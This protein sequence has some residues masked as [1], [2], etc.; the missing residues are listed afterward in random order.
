MIKN[1][2]IFGQ[3]KQGH[4]WVE[5]VN[6]RQKDV[7]YSNKPPR[8]NNRKNTKGRHTQ[9]ITCQKGTSF[10]P[11]FHTKCIKHQSL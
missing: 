4:E 10:P 9:Y 3:L 5:K 11:V 7:N 1:D 6:Q 8:K 2:S